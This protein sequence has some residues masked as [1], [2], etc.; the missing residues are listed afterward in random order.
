MV[1]L[2]LP[3]ERFM[4]GGPEEVPSL[5]APAN[6]FTHIAVTG[7]CCAR[8]SDTRMA[9]RSRINRHNGETGWLPSLPKFK[10][11]A[12]STCH[13]SDTPKQIGRVRAAP[14][15]VAAL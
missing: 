9:R 11:K 5:E 12:R 2:S 7:L 1:G 14:A 13:S 6:G 10:K 15:G 8:R 3:A 4:Q